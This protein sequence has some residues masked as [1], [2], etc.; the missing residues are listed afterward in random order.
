MSFPLLITGVLFTLDLVFIQNLV[1]NDGPTGWRLVALIFFA[2]SLP[3]LAANAFVIHRMRS[4][5]TVLPGKAR[6]FLVFQLLGYIASIVGVW[7]NVTAVSWWIGLIFA[8]VSVAA[9]A[10]CIYALNTLDRQAQKNDATP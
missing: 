5:K 10:M 7:A 1:Q 8:L 4:T 9:A 2:V 6:L 3:C